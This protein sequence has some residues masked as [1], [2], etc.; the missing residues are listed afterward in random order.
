MQDTIKV[1][2]VK[3]PGRP[4]LYM[5]Y[6]DPT[7]GKQVARSTKASNLREAEKVA[8]KW[9]AELQ[10]GRYAKPSRMTWEDF[11]AYYTVHATGGLAVN[12]AAGYESTLNAFERIC[13]P[14]KLVDVTTQRVTA[15]VTQL[16]TDKLSEATVARQLRQ[17]KAA[18]RWANR[19]GLLTVLPRFTMPKR[20]KGAKIMRGRPIC[21][22]EFERMLAATAKV[23]ENAAAESW[24]FYLRGLWASGLRLTESLSLRWDDAPGSIVVD[25][26]SRRPMLRIPAEAEKGHTDRLLPITPEFATLLQGVAERDRRDRRGRVFKLLANDGTLLQAEPWA[27]SK[28]VSAIGQAAGVVVDERQVDGVTARKFA[29]AHDLRRAFGQRWA[30]KVMPT[31]LRELMRHAS[32]ATTMAYYVGSNAEATADVL[33]ASYSGTTEVHSIESDMTKTKSA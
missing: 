11:R 17:M 29:S 32:I 28:V 13:R 19:E 4:A 25:L 22:E 7:T 8:A 12:T 20:V 23:V 5:R 9:E 18:M 27:V 21:F 14:G 10:E 30:A 31:V 16:R 26:A 1:H 3:Y 15:F 33:W 6:V 24:R 2:V